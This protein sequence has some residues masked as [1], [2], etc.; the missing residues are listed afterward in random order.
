VKR[1]AIT[2]VGL[3]SVA[4]R[5]VE[6]HARA[7]FQAGPVELGPVTLFSEGDVPSSPVAQV[8]EKAFEKGPRDSRTDALALAAA[9]DA[10]QMAGPGL[11]SSGMVV[12]GTTTGGMD[13]AEVGYL[14]SR[15][16]KKPLSSGFFRRHPAGAVTDRIASVLE[17]HGERQTFSTACSSSANAIGYA[18]LRIGM[19]ATPWALAGGVDALCQLT[20]F[21][22]HSLR[23]LSPR[24]CQPFH[25]DRVGLS[26]GEG[27]AFLVLEDETL[28]LGRGARILGYVRGWGCTADAHHLTAPDPTGRGAAEAMTEALRDADLTAAQ[29]GYVN[30]HGTGTPANDR[31]EAL[32]LHVAL[33]GHVPPVSSTKGLTGHTLGAA[34]ALEAALT[35]LSLQ[36]GLLPSTL[37]LDRPD[38]QTE[39]PHIVGTPLKR[40]VQFAMSTS[41]GFGGNNAALI[42]ERGLS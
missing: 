18:A 30:A 35:V 17:L 34:G 2:G 15:L 37:R 29:L 12:V 40:S 14:E 25:Q 21:G 4:G 23:L 11:D 13:L 39:L 7:L 22:F 38:P 28:A 9:H 41:F 36:R 3:L 32:A 6:A 42:L 10:R 5:G 20:Y 31:A 19:G 8:P 27:A 1:V 16:Q 24:P 33:A 26:L